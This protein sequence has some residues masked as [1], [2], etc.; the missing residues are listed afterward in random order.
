M[1]YLMGFISH[2]A[3]ST[4]RRKKRTSPANAKHLQQ[5]HAMKTLTR[6]EYD[7]TSAVGS[8]EY[9]HEYSALNTHC[10]L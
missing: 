1:I 3:Q 10:T 2:T 4:S 8:N 9:Y 6:E 7:S 5:M